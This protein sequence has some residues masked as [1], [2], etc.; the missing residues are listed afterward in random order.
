MVCRHHAMEEYQIKCLLIGAAGLGIGMS[1]LLIRRHFAGGVCKSKAAMIGKTVVIT[2]ANTGIGKETALDLAKRNAKVILACRDPEKGRRAVSDII[3]KSGNPNVVFRRLDLASFNSIRNFAFEILSEETTIDVL[4]NNAGVMQCP[5]WK[6]VDGNE[7]HFGVNHLGHFLLTN[8]LLERLM[9]AP[10]ARIVVVS[11]RFYERINGIKFDDINSEKSYNPSEAYAQSKL[12][13]ILFTRA[14]AK[15]L[16]ETSVT[17]NC[18]H[19][20]VIR[21]EL[22]RHMMK[23]IGFLKKV[24]H[25][26]ISFYVLFC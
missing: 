4:I 3:K 13:N 2:G 26:N 9:Q 18:L 8:L 11:S 7:M 16:E 6:T 15:R 23:N 17:V 24:R 22:G 19:P 5:Y 1:F 10:D 20:G 12:A 21:T 14:L 25:V